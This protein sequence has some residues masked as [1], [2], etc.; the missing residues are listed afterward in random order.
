LRRWTL[1]LLG[2]V[3][4]RTSGVPGDRATLPGPAKP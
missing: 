2:P 4:H 3:G 1:R